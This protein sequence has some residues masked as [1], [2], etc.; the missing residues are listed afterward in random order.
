MMENTPHVRADS[1][2]VEDI[3]QKFVYGRN[4]RDGVVV[5]VVGNVQQEKSLGEAAGKVEGNKLP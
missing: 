2:N 1:A 5:A 4:R 3:I